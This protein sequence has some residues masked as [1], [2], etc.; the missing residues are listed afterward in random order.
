VKSVTIS[1]VEFF[2]IL[3]KEIRKWNQ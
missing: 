1:I 2:K 3:I